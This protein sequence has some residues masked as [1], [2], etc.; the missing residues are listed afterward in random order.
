MP[1]SKVVYNQNTLID[2]TSDTVSVDTLKK[3]FTAHKADGT[4]I[5]GNF[6][7]D[8]YDKIDRILTAGLTD[9]WKHF[10][11]D[12]TIISTTDS[13]GRT[14]VKTF[15]NNFL[16]CTTVLKDPNGVE[17]GRTVKSFSDNSSTI[18]T[19][20]SKGQRLIKSFSNNMRNMVAVLTD[21]NNNE[22]ARL[23]KVFSENGKDITSTVVYGE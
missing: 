14:L 13:E 17:L 1:V 5:T 21:A 8:D 6:I 11:D 16:T 7:G 15:S 20:D 3:G 2:L 18:I 22:L 12:G 23:T 9:G 4:L 19:T 10:S